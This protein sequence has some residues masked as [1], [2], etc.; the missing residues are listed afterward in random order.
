MNITNGS[1]LANPWKR[2]KL[3]YVSLAC[4]LALAGAIAVS[5][6][7]SPLPR[8][9][10]DSGSAAPST[11]ISFPVKPAAALYIV[12]SEDEAA[13]LELARKER[14]LDAGSWES[15][16]IARSEQETASIQQDVDPQVVVHDLRGRLG[17]SGSDA[18]A[19]PAQPADNTALE[20]AIIAH[21]AAGEA[22]LYGTTGQ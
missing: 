1:T 9:G 5:L 17:A 19:G 10:S 20:Q 7:A 3:Q 8:S 16:V 18:H 4:G 6:D 21:A 15:T 12:G 11:R 14:G 2:I 22:A 13:I